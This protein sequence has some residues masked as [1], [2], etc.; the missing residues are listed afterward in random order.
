MAGV[1]DDYALISQLQ[2]LLVHCALNSTG[3]HIKIEI[4][5][6][7]PNLWKHCH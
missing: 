7:R 6:D 1:N 5:I 2:I 3:H 4:F